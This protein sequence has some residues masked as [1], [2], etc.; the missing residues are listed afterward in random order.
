MKNK[1]A[2]TR[3]TTGNIQS[4]FQTTAKNIQSKMGNIQSEFN[5]INPYNQI[6]IQMYITHYGGKQ[7][8]INIT[9]KPTSTLMDVLVQLG[10]QCRPIS[11]KQIDI[12]YENRKKVDFKALNNN[13]STHGLDRGGTLF[14]YGIN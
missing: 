11:G 10:K 13:L 12:Y 4:K 6:N 1:Q 8:N 7:E 2:F 14:I 5:K 9:L 3:P